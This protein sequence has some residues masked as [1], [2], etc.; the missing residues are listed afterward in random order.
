[1]QTDLAI[2]V[3]RA[4]AADAPAVAELVNR[5]YSI[6]TFFVEGDRTTAAEIERM[7]ER[8]LFVVLD[9]SVPSGGGQDGLAAAVYVETW[10]YL[11][12]LSVHPELQGHGLGKRLVGIAE[13]LC[14]AAGCRQMNLKIINLRQELHRWYRSLGYAD[15][16]TAPYE[17]RPVKQP[18]HF[19]EMRKT[20]RAT[21]TSA[22]AA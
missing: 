19:I 3:R 16:G 13:A 15:V 10:G 8:G 2:S 22:A 20:L 4:T 18:C 1:M 17:H 21:S 9:V 14:E 12:M 6:E 11:G 5:A 7:L